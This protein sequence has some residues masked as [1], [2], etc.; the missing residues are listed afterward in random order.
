MSAVS[1]ASDRFAP[2][3][4]PG[5]EPF[6]ALGGYPHDDDQRVLFHATPV[7]TVVVDLATMAVAP[8]EAFRQL[9]GFPAG[10][11]TIDD[12]EAATRPPDEDAAEAYRRSLVG[13]ATVDVDQRYV[14]RDGSLFW[15]HLTAAPLFDADGERWGLIGAIADVTDRVEARTALLESEQRFRALVQNVA[16]AI[17]VLDDQGRLLYAS[18]SGESLTG[19][20]TEEFVGTD[21]FSFIHR[22]DRDVVARTYASIFS[23]A[24]NPAEPTV[25]L[26]FRVVHNDGSVRFVEAVATNLLDDPAVNGVVVNVRD[27]TDS[28]V[29]QSAL[30]LT[31]SRFRR[32]IENISDTITLLDEDA[33]VVRHGNVRPIFGHPLEFW[34]GRRLFDLVHADDRE[35]IEAAFDDLRTEP[36]SGMTDEM[37]V[38]IADGSWIDFEVDAVNLLHDPDV[39]AVVITSRDITERKRAERELNQARDQ[40]VQAL[41]MRTEFIASVSHELRSPIH[42][43]LGLSELLA[44]ATLDDD[45]RQLAQSIGRATETLQMVLDDILDYAK[46]EVGRLELDPRP[47]LV[48]EIADDLAALYG[49]EARAK[50]IDLSVEA[51]DGSPQRV[52]ADGLRVRQVLT[53]L[54]GNAVKFTTEGEVRV[55]ASR[56][57]ARGDGITRVRIEVSDTGIGIPPDAHDRLFQPFSQAHTSTA[58]EFGGSGLGLS[59]AKRL[60]G[61]M[62]GELGF[63]S[64]P[65]QGSTFWF[66]LPVEELEELEER[67]IAAL[68]LGADPDER[69]AAKPVMVVEDNAVNQLLV[70][71][72]LEHLGFEAI[73]FESGPAAID[74]YAETDA[75]VVLMDWQLPGMD[76]LET[77]R[78]LRAIERDLGLARTPIVAMTASSRPGDRERCLASGMDDFIAKPVSMGTLG[79]VIGRWAPGPVGDRDARPTAAGLPAGD[80][81]PTDPVGVRSGSGSGAIDVLVLDRLVE[82]LSDP[83]LVAS[84]VRTYLRELPLRVDGIDQARV[85]HDPAPMETACHLLRS[86]SA[87]VGASRLAEL[88]RQ[89][90]SGETEPDDAVVEQVRLEADVVRTELGRRLDDLVVAPPTV[91]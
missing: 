89:L 67:S 2:T 65:M 7:P 9:F 37:R 76:G 72:Q 85:T 51:E 32:M 26:Q 62:G 14:R 49:P 74:R 60:V 59:I 70:R 12:L 3:G 71:R 53:N 64:V 73:V 91:V 23:D 36:G 78:R 81:S 31:E 4:S 75:S 43:V 29:A 54:V 28:A 19:N 21:I 15:G 87:A 27:L 63:E 50:G 39:A 41:Q 1:P 61:L 42:G 83:Q 84:V 52:R 66:V 33:S 10:P 5:T 82:D 48:S 88:C 56:E 44:S 47:L 22:D 20:R 46:I 34:E 80:P 24:R 57:P 79:E 16:D 86:T 40:A 17:V 38:R 13:G 68:G 25:P 35:R 11:I 45:A 58:R 69:P 77:T 18:P 6:A 90:E 30:E 8:N 55:R